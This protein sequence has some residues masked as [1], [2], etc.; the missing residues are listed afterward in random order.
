MDSQ[1][2][3]D[4]SQLNKF[5]LMDNLY[6]QESLYKSVLA[7]NRFDSKFHNQLLLQGQLAHYYLQ[8]L[9]NKDLTKHLLQTKNKAR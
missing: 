1:L 7:S 3:L 4:S 6:N 5:W 9:H 2:N 8:I